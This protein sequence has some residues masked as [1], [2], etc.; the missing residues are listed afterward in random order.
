MKGGRGPDKDMVHV[1]GKSLDP[2]FGNDNR[3]VWAERVAHAK[4]IERVLIGGREVGHHNVRVQ[5]LFIHRL[6]D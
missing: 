5:E 2:V 6:V 3:G 4:L 1:E